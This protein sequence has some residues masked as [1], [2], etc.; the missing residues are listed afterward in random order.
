MNRSLDCHHYK[1]MQ[2]FSSNLFYTSAITMTFPQLNLML[3]NF[4]YFSALWAKRFVG[5]EWILSS[6]DIDFK[7]LFLCDSGPPT[8]INDLPRLTWGL[9]FIE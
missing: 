3:S 6:N 4:L 5:N 9:K 8:Q 1:R 2:A 7:Y